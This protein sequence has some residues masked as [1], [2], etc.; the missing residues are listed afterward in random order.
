MQLLHRAVLKAMTAPHGVPPAVR[1]LARRFGPLEFFH[2]S[3]IGQIFIADEEIDTFL[4]F[5]DF[6]SLLTP[7][8]ECPIQC[9]V[10]L[11]DGRGRP[12]VRKEFV[13]PPH[14]SRALSVSEVL[15]ERGVRCP[16]GLAAAHLS[17][18]DPRSAER[19]LYKKMGRIASHFF[20]YYLNRSTEAMAII[21][22]QSPIHST[23]QDPPEPGGW[24]SGQLIVAD[25]LEGISLYQANHSDRSAQVTYHL[26]EHPGDRVL[27]TRT[28]QVPG[29]SANVAHFWTRDVAPLPHVV[30]VRVERFPCANGKPLLMRRYADG[31]FS[32][33]HS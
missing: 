11:H 28:I 20:T 17:P 6:Y 30:A 7:E 10:D 16:L 22:P 2:E 5:N 23:Q 26:C 1:R 3:P 15:A 21:H 14:G 18:L 19:E 24:R 33:S 9:R 29:L 25:G 13:L 27:A 8:V 32:M 12:V 31:R 4:C